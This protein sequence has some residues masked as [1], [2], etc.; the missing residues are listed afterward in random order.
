[1]L[2]KVL[3][4]MMRDEKG[5]GVSYKNH[6]SGRCDM[7]DYAVCD[8]HVENPSKPSRISYDKMQS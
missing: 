7:K 1:M 3:K 8:D 4:V 6:Q 2:V 5:R